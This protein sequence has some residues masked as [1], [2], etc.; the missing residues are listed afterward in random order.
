MVSTHTIGKRPLNSMYFGQLQIQQLLK[1]HISK[2]LICI[3]NVF[4]PLNKEALI[5]C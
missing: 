5:E 1:Q 2:I 3:L 4:K